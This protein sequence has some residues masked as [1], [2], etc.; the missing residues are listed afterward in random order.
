MG[1]VRGTRA[2]GQAVPAYI[3]SAPPPSANTLDVGVSYALAGVIAVLTYWVPSPWRY[4]YLLIG[5]ACFP[6]A[7]SAVRPAPEACRVR[8]SRRP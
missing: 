3:R 2:A 1:I 4:A 6:L 5:L 8:R 7:R